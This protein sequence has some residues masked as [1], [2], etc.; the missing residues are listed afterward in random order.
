MFESD[1]RALLFINGELEDADVLRAIIQPGDTLV[2]VDGGLRH[3]AALDL[4]ADWI[5][6]DLDSADPDEVTRQ[7]KRGARVEKFPPEKDETDLE[8]ALQ[9]VC[10]A[11][12]KDI[13]L[14]SALG[15]RLD[16]LLGNLFILAH[17]MLEYCQVRL[18][19]GSTEVFLIRHTGQVSGQPGDTV[20]LLPLHGPVEGITTQGLRYPLHAES[21]Y[22]DRARGV[23][24]QLTA[25][26]AT[27]SVEQGML[28]CIHTHESTVE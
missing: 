7:Q 19:Q 20:S 28:L 10:Q 27:I 21:L 22:P 11:G 6:G 13:L 1:K 12:F 17:P 23:S 26:L 18:L 16:Q 9:S 2:A 14:L 8:L 25:P 5:I 3:L 24:N 4:T 15:G